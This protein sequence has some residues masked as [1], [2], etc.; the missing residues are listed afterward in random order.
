MSDYYTY[1]GSIATRP[2]P[3]PVAW[4]ITRKV[5]A[6]SPEQV[7]LMTWRQ[8]SEIRTQGASGKGC[9]LFIFKVFD[10]C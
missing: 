5:T 6:I 4:I 8:T 2:D 9:F 10:L 7:F 1:Y 3:T